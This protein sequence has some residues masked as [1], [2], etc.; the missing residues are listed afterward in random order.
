MR[1]LVLVVPTLAVACLLAPATASATEYVASIADGLDGPFVAPQNDV[2]AATVRYDDVAGR[3][4]VTVTYAAEDASPSR[5]LSGDVSCTRADGQ[6]TVVSLYGGNP[7]SWELA[8][9][10]ATATPQYAA[11]SG[12]GEGTTRTPTTVSSSWTDLRLAGLRCSAAWIP[13]PKGYAPPRPGYVVDTTDRAPFEVVPPVPDPPVDGAPQGPPTAGVPA[14]GP[15]GGPAAAPAAPATPTPA[16]PKPGTAR[17]VDRAVRR[18]S[19]FRVRY[20]GADRIVRVRYRKGARTI[21]KRFT[22]RAGTVRVG[23]RALAP[24]RWRV[25]VLDTTGKVGAGVVR[26]RR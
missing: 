26:V 20:T 9:W 5:R 4:A 17:I 10:G 16:T 2:V 18:G 24:G 21:V 7:G 19:A 22:A 23:T 3:F 25:S 8:I 1:R 14:P 11:M 15:S 12:Q 13:A 6:Q